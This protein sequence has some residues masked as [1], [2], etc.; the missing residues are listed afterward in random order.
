MNTSSPHEVT[1]LLLA[2]ND[3]DSDALAKLAPLVETELRRLA[4]IYLAQERPG[5]TLQPTALVNEAFIKLIDAS[6]VEWKNRAHFFGITAQLMRHILV[7]HARRRQALK[8]GGEALR[9]SLIE[10]ENVAPNRQACIIELDE[11]LSAL[12][13]IDPRKSRIVELKFFGGLS[14]EEIAKLLDTSLRTV[15]RDWNLARAW[16]FRQL[17]KDQHHDS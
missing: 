3:G 2:W 7:D 9:V 1:Q 12:S 11:A 4:K 13:R 16:L 8:H 5:H 6:A 17:N 10:A 14:E 15:Q